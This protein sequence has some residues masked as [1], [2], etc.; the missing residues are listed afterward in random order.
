MKLLARLYK[1]FGDVIFLPIPLRQKSPAIK[2]W[3]TITLAQ[4][5]TKAFQRKLAWFAEKGNIG[6]RQGPNLQ[7]IDI[8]NDE[9][10]E[11]FLELNPFLRETAITKAKR[12]IT[13]HVRVKGEYPNHQAV[14]KLTDKKS[15]AR[16]MEWRCG[17]GT[18]G[19]QSVVSGVHPDGMRYRF[20]SDNPVIE[21]TL[22]RITWL[23]NLTRLW[24]NEAQKQPGQVEPNVRVC[25]G[26]ERL[27]EQDLFKR[28]ADQHGEPI[29]WPR[30]N[31]PALNEPY[32]AGV[33]AHEHYVL[34]EAD[35][36]KFYQYDGKDGLY[37]FTSE[38]QI[39]CWLAHRLLVLSRQHDEMAPL[40]MLRSAR[41]LSG[42]VR[43]L[44]GQVEQKE[45][46]ASNPNLIH[47]ANGVL[48]LSG[49]EIKLLPFLPEL[50][51]RNGIPIDYVKGVTAKKFVETILVLLSPDDRV[52][53][54][55]FIGQFLTGL[56][57][58]QKIL[59]LYGLA[60]T[61]KSTLAQIIKWLIGERNC[62]E[63]RTRHL[64]S[65][66]EIGRLYGRT[67]IIGADVSPRFLDEEGSY[68][69]KAIVGGDLLDAEKKCS[70]VY[71]TMTGDFNVLLTSN[72][73]LIVRLSGDRG[74]WERRLAMIEHKKKRE[75]KTIE[76]FARKLIKEEGSGILNLSLDGLKALRADLKSH[77][78]VV[79]TDEQR[80]RVKSLLDES[81]GLRMFLKE[82]VQTKSG[83]SLT[84]DELVRGFASY[85]SE[86]GWSMSTPI[87]EKRLVHLMLELFSV[88]RSNNIERETEEG[89]T[90]QHRG[91]RS[92]IWR[93]ENDE[94]SDE[95]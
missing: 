25:Q 90:T 24:D 30:K 81:D 55:K 20:I 79:L 87:V 37:H 35:E 7:S 18:K 56:N 63:L 28:L 93:P 95:N 73:K 70:N 33:Y 65:R 94:Y 5:K 52:L 12:G 69:L 43:H 88:N 84:T 54:L 4:T 61:S 80:A 19:S 34:F 74:A 91:Y 92:V 36:Q 16:V 26:S 83:S 2:K 78:D 89:K 15:G 77:G 31:T 66:F 75:G 71:F 67:L 9:L 6:V 72:S 59:I 21:T 68:R 44:K 27:A 8:D 42:V 57:L 50:K 85:C 11:R 45:P 60:D 13:I 10:A 32:F 23:E 64:A 22:D 76:N 51:S 14:Y 86:R 3:E 41:H 39:L 38:H 47:V 62:T 40:E 82:K 17:G 53:L 49:D 58:T 29:Q 1:I 48:D 46:F